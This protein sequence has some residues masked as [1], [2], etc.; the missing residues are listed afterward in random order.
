LPKNKESS[1]EFLERM[2]RKFE[3]LIKEGVKFYVDTIEG[4]LPPEE[5]EKMRK[6][7]EEH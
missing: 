6:M 7:L 4:E 2:V 1:E 3:E 5:I